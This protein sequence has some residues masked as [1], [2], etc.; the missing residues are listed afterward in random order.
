[1]KGPPTSLGDIQPSADSNCNAEARTPHVTSRERRF[2]LREQKT[3]PSRLAC[4]NPKALRYNN[5]GS[6]I[7]K[8]HSYQVQAALDIKEKGI[9]YIC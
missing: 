4:S 6:V 1:M 8:G 5:V 9:V 2:P 7:A 3:L